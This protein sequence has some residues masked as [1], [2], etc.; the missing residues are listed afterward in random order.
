MILKTA[1]LGWSDF[2]N[3]VEASE[4]ALATYKITLSAAAKSGD[5][6]QR[7]E[8]GLL[9]A[10]VLARYEFPGKRLI[11]AAVDLPFAL[12]A[13]IAGLALI[14]SLLPRTAGSDGFLERSA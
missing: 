13:A 3:I 7:V 8:F 11:D 4:R 14:T 1:S 9:L 6:V 12:P 10:W 2:W 5:S